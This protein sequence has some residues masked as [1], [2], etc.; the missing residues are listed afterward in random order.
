[1]TEEIKALAVFDDW[2]DR[3]IQH[4]REKGL[5][6]DTDEAARGAKSTTQ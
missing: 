3:F 2:V 1:L 6:E 5:V 4:V